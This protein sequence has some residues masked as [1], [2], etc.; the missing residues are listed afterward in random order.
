[1][2]INQILW[3]VAVSGSLIMASCAKNNSETASDS[4]STDSSTEAAESYSI[5]AESSSVKWFGEMLGMYS[6]NGEIAVRE[7]SVEVAGG[8]L[9]GGSVVIDMTSINP[10]DNGY[11]DEPGR[12]R[13]DLIGH[14]SSPDFF[15]VPN[16][17][18]ATFTLKSVNGNTGTGTLTLRGTTSEETIENLSFSET[19]SGYTVT[20]DVTFDRKKYGA[21]FDMT[22]PDMVLS[23]DIKISVALQ[24]SK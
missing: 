7:G 16:N 14:L 9:V 8:K 12:S 5:N 10:T 19:E 22:I 21:K 1:M 2:K 11:K 15:D 6:H 20:G 13:A 23:D 18:T 4:G 17:P 24:A 3:M